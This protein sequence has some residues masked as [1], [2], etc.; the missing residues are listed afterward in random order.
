L[1]LLLDTHIWIWWL[2]DDP[3][4]SIEARSLVED[5]K[6]QI[7]VSAISFW[8]VVVKSQIG[9]LQMSDR[10]EEASASNNIVVLPFRASHALAVSKLPL[11][12]RDPF[13]RALIAQSV[14]EGLRFMTVDKALAAYSDNVDLLFVG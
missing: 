9:K 12:H 11:H 5:P 7:I 2:T 13:D 6:N 3:S 1:N 4:L 8:E 14:A 10:L